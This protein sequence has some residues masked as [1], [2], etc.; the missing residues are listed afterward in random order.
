[1]TGHLTYDANVARL[2]E[3]RRRAE[4]RRAARG[5]GTRRIA[6]GRHARGCEGGPAGVGAGLA[7][8]EAVTIRRAT[9]ADRASLEL[10]AALDSA[11]TPAGEVLIA[12]VG[13]EAWGAVEVAS[14][15]TI[16][17]PFR[18]T[19]ELVELLSL[20]AARLRGGA[21]RRRLRLRPRAA[22]RAA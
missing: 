9:E 4:R 20:R 18:P 6:A 19:A 16:A 22:Y 13:D 14:G 1:V 3:L 2:E 5:A 11:R 10:L 17:D 15:A 21:D 7:M 12:E 8:T